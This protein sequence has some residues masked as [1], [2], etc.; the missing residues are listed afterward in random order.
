MSH[1][2][3]PCVAGIRGTVHA[4]IQ[5]E[6]EARELEPW[7]VGVHRVLAYWL[8]A[9]WD[10]VGQHAHDSS[11]LCPRGLETGGEASLLWGDSGKHANHERDV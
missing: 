8:R 11:S 5:A 1:G 7:G 4:P 3:W 9:G 10:R 6:S 2:R